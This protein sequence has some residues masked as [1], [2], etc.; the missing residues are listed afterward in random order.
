MDYNF[1][2]TLFITIKFKIIVIGVTKIFEI[3]AEKVRINCNV[4]CSSINACT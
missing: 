4:I 2:I 1:S 3:I